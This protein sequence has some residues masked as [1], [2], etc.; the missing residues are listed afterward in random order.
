MPLNLNNWFYAE[1]TPR[2]LTEK[3]NG[4]WLVGV[5]LTITPAG[6]LEGCE[7][8]STSGIPQLD[9][10]S[11]RTLIRRAK[12]KPAR[13]TDGTSAVGVFRTS[14]RWAVSDV[15]F[16]ISNVSKPDLDL[17]VQSLPGK[18][19]SPELV[20][21][22]FSVGTSGELADCSAEPNSVSGRVDSDP[23]L[24]EVACEQLSKSYKPTPARDDKGNP[25]PSVQNGLVR[26]TTSK[27]S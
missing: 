5:R 25:V 2:Y 16:D 17:S 4:L 1:D 13:W 20:Y 8:E 21:I 6:T 26:F 3:D 19:H 10:F 27:H 9:D 22:M 15:P 23:T 11:C 18:V 7:I 12:F 24:V 14:V